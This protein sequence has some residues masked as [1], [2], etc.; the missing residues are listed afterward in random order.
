MSRR[1]RHPAVSFALFLVICGM[2]WV[3]YENRD[4]FKSAPKEEILTSE[5]KAMLRETIYE[6]WEDDEC[7]LELR[8]NLNWRPNAQRY[9]LDI[10]VVDGAACEDNARQLCW[11]I[12][13]LIQR[14]TGV[15]A[16]VVAYD[17][18]GREVGRKVL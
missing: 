15:V 11:D 6:V 10:V 16:T 18:A 13:L 7:F 14:E 8:S 5:V 3:A 1:N 17:R 4:F 9:L 2:G 12:A